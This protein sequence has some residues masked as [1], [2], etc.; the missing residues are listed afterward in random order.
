MSSQRKGLLGG[1]AAIAFVV[2]AILVGFS[3][4]GEAGPH[5]APVVVC[6]DSTV[7]TDEVRETYL[8]D[9]KAVAHSAALKQARFYAAACGSNATGSVNW[10]IRKQF[11]R[12]SYSGELGEESIEGQV[13]D[14]SGKLEDLV[15]AR[16]SLQGT[17]L[18]E[19]LAVAARQ[20]EHAGGGCSIYLFTDGE[21]ADG[22]LHLPREAVSEEMVDRYLETYESQIGDLSGTVVNFVGVGY[23]TEIGE[24]RLNEAR[25]I[26]AALIAAAGGEMGDWTVRL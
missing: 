17:P 12:G 22:I 15:A 2:A 23:G 9:I 19:M 21:W 14:V 4:E 20:C 6:V 1:S 5:A 11:G 18:G 8:P 16:S 13:E 25:S 7:S 3:G 10:P 26:A 24:I